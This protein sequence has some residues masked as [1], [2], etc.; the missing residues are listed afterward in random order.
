MRRIRPITVADVEFI[1][2]GVAK[3]LMNYDEP[4]P[5]FG[6]RYPNTLESCI[7]APFQTFE[8]KDLYPGLVKKASLLCYLM[9]KNHPFQNGNKRL[10]VTTTLVFLHLNGKW[11]NMNPRQLYE[12]TMWIAQSSPD[13]KDAA[14]LALETTINKHL[15][16]RKN[17]KA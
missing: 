2:H 7:A 3:E 14:L 6:T 13:V 10:A 4:I 8:R 17:S 16:E 11:L 15:T 1:A 9:I 5:D 12:F